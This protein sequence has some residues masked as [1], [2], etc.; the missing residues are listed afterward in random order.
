MAAVRLARAGASVTLFDPSHPREK[1]CGGGLTG[2]A[3]ALVADVIDI[4]SLAGRRRRS[5]RRSKAADPQRARCRADRSRRDARTARCSSSAAP[6]S[7]ARSSMR[8][9]RPA[10]AWS[11]RRA[12]RRRAAA[13]RA[14]SFAPIAASTKSTTCSALTARTASC[15]RSSRAPFARA[16]LS[17]AAGFFVHGATASSD[18]H[19]DDAASRPDISGRFPDPIILRSASA[20]RPRIERVIGRAA[21][22]VAAWIEQHG[23]HHGHDADAVRLAHPEHRLR[24]AVAETSPGRRGMDAAR[25]CR[26]PGRSADARRHLLRAAVGAVGRRGAARDAGAARGGAVRRPV[27][28]RGSARARA[29]R[30]PERPVLHPGVLRAAG[31]GARRERGAFETSSS[32]WS[33]GVQPY[34]G[35]RRRLLATREWTL[36]ARAI[37][38]APDARVYWYNDDCRLTPG[39][40]TRS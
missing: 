28:E 35:L 23:L 26:G 4:R 39:N 20:P 33:A 13:V 10:R 38:H 3:L 9:S 5:P 15:A 7:T 12:D 36:A 11:A 29:R 1:P 22:A 19:Q 25:R 31:A 18:R 21:R 16:Q 37:R 24:R 2:R 8:R 17:V 34:R 14:W 27:L 40:A 32:T 30:A 6:S